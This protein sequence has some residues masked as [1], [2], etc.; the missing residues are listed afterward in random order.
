MFGSI[1][2]EIQQPTSDMSFAPEL[3]NGVNLNNIILEIKSLSREVI[4]N[5]MILTTVDTSNNEHGKVYVA[6]VTVTCKKNQLTI[7]QKVYT[8][9]M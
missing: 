1:I 6:E 2:E 5:N 4:L 7:S 8:V 9:C 3:L